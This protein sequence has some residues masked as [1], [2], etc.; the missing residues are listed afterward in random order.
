MKKLKTVI[1]ILKTTSKGFGFVICPHSEDIFIPKGAL[2]SAVDGDLVEVELNPI[3]SE[4]GPDGH[5]I[6]IKERGRKN[7]CGI[8]KGDNN[9]IFS[10]LV[11]PSVKISL[12]SKKKFSVGSILLMKV[13]NWKNKQGEIVTEPIENIGSILDPSVDTKFAIKDFQLKEEFSKSAL[14]EAGQL[15]PDLTNRKDLTFLECITIDPDTAKDFDDALSLKKDEKGEFHLG[16]HIA[17][18]AHFVKPGS[19]LDRE[20]LSRCNSTYFPNLCLPM[21]P[22]M[23]SNNLCSLKPKVTKLTISVLMTFDKEGNLKDYQIIRSYIKSRERLTYKEALAILEKGTKSPHSKMLLEM[24][25]LALLLKKKRFNRGSI[26]LT[27]P[28]IFIKVDKKGDSLGVE[29]IEYDI[30][31]QLVEEFMLKANEIIAI[32]LSKTKKNPIYRVHEEPSHEDFA[33]FYTLARSLGFKLPQ[34]PTPKDLSNLFLEAKNSSFEKHLSITLVRSMKL[35]LYSPN[36]IGHFGLALEYYCHF[37]SPIRRYTD[38]ISQRLLFDEEPKETDLEDVASLSSEKERVSAQAENRVLLYKKLRLLKKY[39]KE[40]PNRIYKAT[41]TRLKPFFI[42][43]EISD[44]FVEGSLHISELKKDYFIFNEEKLSFKGKYTGQV[45][46]FG[47]KLALKLKKV[48][49]IFANV[50]W[51]FVK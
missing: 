12:K 25:E 38:L 4:K 44:L 10:P 30:S 31:H 8:I 51:M 36:N 17:D 37:T 24:K 49:L 43:F 1:G 46:S 35:A 15:K 5:I 11:G 41:I 18:V 34:H 16:V 6:A 33:D 29:T 3:C 47:S 22:P 21:L 27:I 26:D 42:F 19:A 23:L 14:K 7:L 28:E 50:E 2:N 20:A 9:S 32:H 45:Y 40:N 39:L 13:V 48:D